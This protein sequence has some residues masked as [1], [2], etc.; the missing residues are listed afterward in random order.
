MKKIAFTIV[1]NGMPFI[2]KQ[3]QIIS[4][5]FDVWYIVEGATLPIKDTAW[6][7]NIDNKFYTDKKLSVDGTTEFL[8]SIK[9]DK[10]K[11]I[12]KNDFWDGKTE[13][14]NSFMHEVENCIL[15]EFDVDEIWKKETL[16]DLLL[17]CENNDIYD[18]LSFKCNYY[19]GP[20]LYIQNEDCYGNKSDEWVRLWKIKEKTYWNSHEPPNLNN[21]YRILKKEF[22]KSKGWMFDH[23]AYVFESQLSFKENFYGYKNALEEW[24]KLQ[25]NKTFPIH[26][27]KFLSWVDDKAIVNKI[28]NKLQLDNVTILAVNGR[29]PENS[30]KAINFSSKNIDFKEKLLITNNDMEV[31]G[32]RVVNVGGLKSSSDYSLFCAHELYKHLNTD[33][34]IFI[35]P[36]GFIVNPHLWTDD[37]LKYDYI[38]APW[39]HGLSMS[40]LD[41]CN[42]TAKNLDNVNIVGN[43]GFSF[44]SKKILE[45]ASKLEYSDPDKIEEDCFFSVLK[46]NE[47]QNSG[48]KYAPVSLAQRFSIE[49]FINENSKL[50]NSFGFH[51]R[52]SYFQHYIDQLNSNE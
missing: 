14:C 35:Q 45:E 12:R 50:E 1:L 42:M 10:I 8:D 51:G 25:K 44:R 38:G 3:A 37:F 39:N 7:K 5:I 48:C 30:I 24:E 18:G 31:D 16:K 46:R 34:C 4:E 11:I 29:D 28:N 27:N 22:T 36:D 43:G 21:Y 6:C 2:K 33:Y 23:Y 41:K 20:D 52:F 15:M 32:F 17:Y 9:S 49:T 47:L 19:V 13:M 40:V 26:L